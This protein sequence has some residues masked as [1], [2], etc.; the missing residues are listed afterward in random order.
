MKLDCSA[1]QASI[2]TPDNEIQHMKYQA[3][4]I[5]ISKT[6]GRNDIDINLNSV[7]TQNN[8]S[9]IEKKNETPTNPQSIVPQTNDN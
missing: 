3:S 8:M 6:L 4:N 2:V 9:I 1:S 7:H 5:K